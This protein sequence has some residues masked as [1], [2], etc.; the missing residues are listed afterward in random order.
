MLRNILFSLTARL[1]WINDV[2]RGATPRLL[3]LFSIQI[4]YRIFFVF[5]SEWGSIPSWC[6]PNPYNILVTCIASIFILVNENYRIAVSFE[7]SCLILS[8]FVV[9][10]VRSIYAIYVSCAFHSFTN[11]F[12]QCSFND[13]NLDCVL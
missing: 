7:L 8:S 3:Q 2:F 12:R 1:P 6:F 5:R 9:E 4:L 11:A 10:L 13:F